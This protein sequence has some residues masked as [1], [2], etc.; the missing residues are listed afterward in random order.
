MKTVAL[1]AAL[2]CL[3]SP[4]F[5]QTGCETGLHA[6]KRQFVEPFNAAKDAVARN[7]FAAALSLALLARPH[8]MSLLQQTALTQ[9]EATAY[10]GLDDRAAASTI[11][12]SALSDSCLP[13][14]V[15]TKYIEKLRDWGVPA[16]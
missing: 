9:I 15:R 3:T 10:V 6:A 2:A 13:P 16:N 14:D 4:A 8:T 1:A 12:K 7:D 5:A 11:M